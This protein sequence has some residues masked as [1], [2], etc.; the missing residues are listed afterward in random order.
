MI[1]DDRCKVSNFTGYTDGVV[2]EFLTLF[3]SSDIH[4]TDRTL[5]HRLQ[6]CA[7]LFLQC[8][9]TFCTPIYMSGFQ[10]LNSC[11]YSTGALCGLHNRGDNIISDLQRLQTS[12]V[13]QNVI[14]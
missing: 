8:L 4:F 3:T 11:L 12:H 14:K 5:C 13:I 6:N 9:I 2:I 1:S 10:S 7:V